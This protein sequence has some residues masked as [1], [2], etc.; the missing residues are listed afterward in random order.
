MYQ[1]VILS[2]LH[3]G[4]A[5]TGLQEHSPLH[6]FVVIE[7]TGFAQQGS[8]LKEQIFSDIFVVTIFRPNGLTD[9][10]D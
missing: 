8:K 1:G 3:G 6:Y 9:F 2:Q 5:S 7:S 10:R 4:L